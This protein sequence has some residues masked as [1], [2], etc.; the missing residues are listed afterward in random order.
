MIW[1]GGDAIFVGCYY[2]LSEEKIG[3]SKELV[4]FS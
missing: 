1:E 3:A 4:L 2:S